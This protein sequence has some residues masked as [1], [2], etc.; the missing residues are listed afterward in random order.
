[1][2]SNPHFQNSAR[3]GFPQA[4]DETHMFL[5]PH[6]SETPR[7]EDMM[8]EHDNDI[9]WPNGLSFF[10]ALT[11]RS[12]DAKLLFNPEGLGNKPDQSHHSLFLEGKN[13][14]PEASNMQNLGATNPNEF[15]SLDSH[16]ESARKMENKFKRSFTLPARMASSSSTPVDH[17]PEPGMYSDMETFM[18]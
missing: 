14:N 8:G 9:K 4:K 13:P 2:L 5:L 12:D 17:Q 3:L 18:E 16:A 7:I 10:N 15:L 1:M 11:G 6:S